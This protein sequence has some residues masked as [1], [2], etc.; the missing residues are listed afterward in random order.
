MPL[1]LLIRVRVF[2]LKRDALAGAKAQGLGNVTSGNKP[3]KPPESDFTA[4]CSPEADHGLAARAYAPA[5]DADGP[6]RAP[7]AAPAM[8]ERNRQQLGLTTIAA[9]V[10]FV[11]V[12]VLIAG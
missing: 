7:A 1:D 9:M 12:M 2:E 3:E 10:G 6:D 4:M 5:P 11:L 8:T